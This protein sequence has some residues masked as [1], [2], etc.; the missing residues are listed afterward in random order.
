MRLNQF[1]KGLNPFKNRKP[2]KKEIVKIVS[3]ISA[4]IVLGI[5]LG[6]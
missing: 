2:T 6:I 3:A 5:L 4:Q 1:F